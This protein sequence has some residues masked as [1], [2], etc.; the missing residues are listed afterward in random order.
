MIDYSRIKALAKEHGCTVPDLLAL[1]RQNDPFYVGTPADIAQ[2]EWFAHLWEAAGF[3]DGGHLRR[4][5]YWCVSQAGLEQPNGK[6]Y[7]N[8]DTCWQYMCKASSAARY[9]GLVSFADVRDHK[10]PEPHVYRFTQAEPNARFQVYVPELN[11]P[12]FSLNPREENGRFRDGFNPAMV[13]PYHLEVWCEKSTMNDVL[14][15]ACQQH[16]ANLVTGEGEMSIT[17]VW[18]LVERL[19]ATGKPARIFYISDFD[20][21]GQSMPCAVARKVEWMA[22]HTG[23]DVEIKLCPLVLTSEQQREYGLPRTPIKESELRAARFEEQHGAGAVELDA[24]EALHP[25]ELGRIVGD[26]LGAYWSR[27]ADVRMRGQENALRQAIRAEM[28]AITEGY[29]EEIAALQAMG[30]E[31]EELEV[32]DIGRYEPA[33]ASPGDVLGDG[34][35]FDWLFDTDRDYME[36]IAAYKA[37]KGADAV[38]FRGAAM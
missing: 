34:A 10:N 19:T 21:A 11:D 13:Q 26:A 9:L 22:S 4:M 28:D 7:E 6:P 36:Q 29:A 8:T 27:E 33:P 32:P 17:A 24:L 30:T 23:L 37:H 5:H 31:L 15:P 20:P 35:G 2:A 16:L 18:G 25:G 38:D 14:L 12:D 1:A 3:R